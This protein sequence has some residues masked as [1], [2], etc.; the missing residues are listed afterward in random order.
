MPA[1]QPA[2]RM[3]SPSDPITVRI[4]PAI[5][6]R[7]LLLV[8]THRAPYRVSNPENRL[9]PA[10]VRLRI[11]MGKS[12]ILNPARRSLLRSN[13]LVWASFWTAWPV[14]QDP[15]GIFASW[16]PLAAV[17]AILGTADT[18]R[19]LRKHRDLHHAGVLLMIWADLLAVTL[20]ASLSISRLYLRS[21]LR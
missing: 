6:G 2:K 10:L 9:A 12:R 15:S 8:S 1:S 11:L 5:F 13:V 19:N 20:L 18:C 4:E 7:S 21:T 16:M 17:V 14:Y 3:D